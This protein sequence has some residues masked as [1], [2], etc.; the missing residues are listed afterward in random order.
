MVRRKQGVSCIGELL[1]CS[2]NRYCGVAIGHNVLQS[3]FG[4]EDNFLEQG[5]NAER[6]SFSLIS[7]PSIVGRIPP[8][9]AL[10]LVVLEYVSLHI[11]SLG[12][13]NLR[14]T[15]ELAY[16]EKYY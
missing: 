1:L 12:I 3:L 6:L 11:L 13:M 7:F 8:A 16:G 10:R 4:R 2:R 14:R 15:E 9:S 5:F